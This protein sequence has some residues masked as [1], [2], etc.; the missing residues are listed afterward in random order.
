VTGKGLIKTAYFI[1][2]RDRY[3]ASSFI[4]TKLVM[5]KETSNSAHDP[6]LPSSSSAPLYHGKWFGYHGCTI[7]YDYHGSTVV[8]S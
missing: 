1:P 5:V 8:K 7:V 3:L 2:V 4:A 6:V